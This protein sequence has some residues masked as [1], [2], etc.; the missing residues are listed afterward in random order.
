MTTN[1]QKGRN[2]DQGKTMVMAIEHRKCSY[3]L[4]PSPLPTS[5]NRVIVKVGVGWSWGQ[6]MRYLD[7]GGVGR[8]LVKG[9][10]PGNQLKLLARVERVSELTFSYNHLGDYPNCRHRAFM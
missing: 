2:S 9:K 6:V 1:K 8:N 7:G 3:L 10:L 5:P 4:I